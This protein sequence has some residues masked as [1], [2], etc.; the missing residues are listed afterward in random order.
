MIDWNDL[1]DWERKI[2]DDI[3]L[4]IAESGRYKRCSRL[5]FEILEIIKRE[6]KKAFDE[7]PEEFI[8]TY[9]SSGVALSEFIYEI[10]LERGIE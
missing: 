5:S 2:A 3:F 9:T 6:I 8:K 1:N 4:L 10:F 7:L